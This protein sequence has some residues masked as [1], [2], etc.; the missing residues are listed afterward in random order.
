MVC[1]VQKFLEVVKLFYY[2]GT[3]VHNRQTSQE[4]GTVT[5]FG[6]VYDLRGQR[7]PNN[8]LAWYQRKSTIQIKYNMI[9]I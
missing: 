7:P 8:G 6:H 9:K 5:C 4:T 2:T 1:G 3:L